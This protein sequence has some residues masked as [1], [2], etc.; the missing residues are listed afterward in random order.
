MKK[1]PFFAKY[2]EEQKTD[3][4]KPEGDEKALEIKTGVKVGA[5]SRTLKYPSDTDEY[6]TLKYP[7]DSDEGGWDY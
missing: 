2:L 1:L 5:R 7:S 3:E 6:Q 4:E